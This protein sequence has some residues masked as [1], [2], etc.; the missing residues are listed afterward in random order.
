MNYI[1][2]TP[3]KDE[4]ENLHQLKKIVL[5]QTIKPSIWVIGDGNSTDGSFQIANEIFKG[6]EWIY[7]IK[8]RTF[9]DLGYSH[10]NIA[11]NLND[12]YK[13]TKKL[14]VENNIKYSFVARVDATPILSK[15]YFEIIINEMKKDSKLAFVCGLQYLQ[16]KNSKKI[17]A[18]IEGI[19]KTG[20]NDQGIYRREF[21]EDIGGF[22][23]TYSPETVLQIKALNRGWKIRVI[24]KTYFTK[25]RLG[26]SKIGIF[27]GY[28]LKG[29]SM[30]ALGYNPLLVIANVIYFCH[31][32]T[33][34]SVA[35]MYGYFSSI[36][37]R[38]K[39]IDDE[40]VLEYFGKKRLRHIFLDLKKNIKFKKL[41]CRD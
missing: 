19:S 33:P 10:K 5:N 41:W 34:K 24:E 16:L 7:V 22:P 37:K 8:Q 26:G 32:F 6:Y 12:C 1:L 29:R 14:C 3:I 23:I 20:F 2:I 30:Y 36:I 4:A 13:Y 15:D 9:F 39:R 31:K 18:G 27:K 38:E 28:K 11:G 40:E 25:L 21:L 17:L 35:I